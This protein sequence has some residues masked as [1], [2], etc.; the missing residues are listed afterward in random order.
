MSFI[1][2]ILVQ[3]VCECIIAKAFGGKIANSLTNSL[4][5]KFPISQS[6]TLNPAS[7]LALAIVCSG[8]Q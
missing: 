2:H 5:S 4:R 7:C 1:A 8:L 6:Y 3:N